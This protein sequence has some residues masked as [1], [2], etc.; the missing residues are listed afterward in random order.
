VATAIDLGGRFTVDLGLGGTV[1]F[2]GREEFHYEEYV[3]Q[4]L[5]EEPIVEADDDDLKV[6]QPSAE[7]TSRE[8]YGLH[9]QG[10]IEARLQ[11]DVLRLRWGAIHVA[12]T[13][14][15]EFG[16]PAGRVQPNATIATRGVSA[17]IGLDLGPRP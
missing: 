2:S 12:V 8:R 16:G 3:P 4:G 15:C 14:F 5:A 17:V 7:G 9:A 10:Q 13:A 6:Q 1:F 11:W